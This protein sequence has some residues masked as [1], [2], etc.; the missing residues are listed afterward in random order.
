MDHH[1]ERM[2]A[3]DAFFRSVGHFIK[4]KGGH[5]EHVVYVRNT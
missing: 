3:R 1:D 4:A 2:T 5:F